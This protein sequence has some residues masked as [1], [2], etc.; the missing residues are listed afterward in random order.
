[1]KVRTNVRAGSRLAGSNHNQTLL[2]G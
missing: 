1:L 2:R